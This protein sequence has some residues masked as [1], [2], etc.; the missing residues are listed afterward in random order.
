MIAL[1]RDTNG[2]DADFGPNPLPNKGENVVKPEAKHRPRVG[3][4]GLIR[5][6]DEI[7]LGMR[8]KDPNRGLWVLPGGGVEFGETFEE[9]LTREIKEEANINIVV[10]DAFKTYEL[11][12]PPNEHR[13][14]IYLFADY[15]SG[16]PV[17]SSDLAEVR[18]VG[19]EELKNFKKEGRLSP[20]VERVL[21]E[22][23]LL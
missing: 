16:N 2:T 19:K 17:P 22:A 8:K 13:I 15:S 5:R 9:T 23:E 14:I 11:I 7:L 21:H 3:C 18:F 4:A 20:F 6:G 1:D 12:N 10:R